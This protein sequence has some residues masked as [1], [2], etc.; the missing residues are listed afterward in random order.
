MG[1]APYATGLL[2]GGATMREHAPVAGTGPNGTTGSAQ[3]SL[4]AW[5]VPG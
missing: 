3:C 1:I 5:L 2:T 4:N